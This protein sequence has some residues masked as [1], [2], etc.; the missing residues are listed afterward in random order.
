MSGR[1][2]LEE[3][4]TCDEVCTIE[5]IGGEGWRKTFQFMQKTV[6]ENNLSWNIQFWYK[7]RIENIPL[8]ASC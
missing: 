7:C 8:R 3:Q 1:F 6:S 2:A 5:W 4:T